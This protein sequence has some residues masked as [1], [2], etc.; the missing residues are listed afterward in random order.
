MR[1]FA[2][3][4]RVSTEDH[5]DEAA[6]RGWQLRRARELI[7]PDGGV[8]VA[9]F[10][11]VGQSRS[12]P[13][14]RRPEASRLMAELATPGRS[15]Q[16][17]VIGEPAR[18]FFGN[19]FSLTLPVIDHFGAELWVPEVGGRVDA[20]SEAHEMLMTLFGGMSKGERNRTKVRVKA[21]MADM[22]EREGRFLGGRPPYGYRLVDGGP[23]PNPEKAAA[24]LKLHRLEPDPETGPVVARIFQ[25]YLA[26]A[27]LR[28]IAQVLAD[29]RV[30]SPSAHDKA[31]NPH[32]LGRGW[33]FATV[34]TILQNPR[35]TGYQVWGRQPRHEELLD[36]TAPQD[37]YRTHQR[38]ADTDAW[39]HSSELAQEPL[40]DEATYRRAQALMRAKGADVKRSIR[41]AKT[42]S[43]YLFTGRVTCAMC[44]RKMSGHRSGA[45]LGYACRIRDA[46]AL[47]NADPHP[48]SVWL[49]ERDLTAVALEWL[50]EIFAPANR[51]RV[52]AGIAD[53]AAEPDPD[54]ARAE[55][56]LRSADTQIARL[57]NG[58][59]EGTA[60]SS[61]RCNDSW[62][63]AVCS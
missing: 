25:M 61:G 2:F 32:R 46:Y 17:I 30:P 39:I 11:D 44:G 52:L 49:T 33:S 4:G 29:D 22:A 21:A 7:E 13:W 19:Q 56:D 16:G 6:S 60:S 12:L 58:V 43:Q 1:R 18:A 24:G 42:N 45:R 9:E 62:I 26:G 35:Y 40:V 38:W 31:R 36:P 34:Q 41:S 28:T 48:R 10:F 3:Y 8:I 20:E 57:V 37:G 55:I 15:W 50:A 63:V 23:H 54:L 51:D 47:G 59:A 53:A 27:G 14:S 5:Q